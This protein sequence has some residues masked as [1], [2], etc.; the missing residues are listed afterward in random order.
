MTSQEETDKK[1]ELL[2]RAKEL[3]IKGAHVCG[4]DKLEE[5]IADAEA[6]NEAPVRKV[7]PRMSISVAR[8]LGRDAAIAQLERD[9][10]GYK[11]ILESADTNAAMLAAKGLES[12]GKYLKND[13]IC[14]TD[15]ESYE[16][17]LKD[18]NDRN[19]RV[20]DSVYDEGDTP[21]FDSQA[22]KPKN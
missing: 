1:Q 9:N 20:M 6:A 5:K 3:G 22:K 17:F 11:Y 19:S 8:S 13:L 18:R 7:A 14:R 4:I 15:K 21:S 10:P 12:T 16:E 2:V